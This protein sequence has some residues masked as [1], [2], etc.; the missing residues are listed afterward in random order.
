[1]KLAPARAAALLSCTVLFAAVPAWSQTRPAASRPAVA[2]QP[3]ASAGHN[4][5][6]WE[7]EIA[8]YEALDRA[9]P[10]AKGGVLFI[11]SSTVRLWTTL[12]KDF[13]DQRVL[14]RGFGGSQIVDSTH[15]A[16]RIIFPYEPR[17]VVLRAGSNDIHAGKS[18]EQV[19]ADYRAFVAKV[20]ARLPKAQIVYISI[21]PA[22]ARWAERDAN[23]ALNILVEQYTR[24][25]PYLKYVET[26]A[27]VLGHDGQ[28]RRELF[29]RDRLHFSAEGYRLLA[30]RVRPL[31][32]R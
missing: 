18:P 20:H 24:G 10:P 13:P 4:F 14:N 25:R 5:A 23:K 32:P 8:A 15:F 29:V 12:D 30:E 3:A 2:T 28:P 31:L 26:Y 21:S 9:H 1:M 17:M 11:G 6:R 22:P 16:E 27:M 19:Y 7:K